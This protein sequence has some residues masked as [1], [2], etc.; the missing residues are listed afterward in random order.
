MKEGLF[1]AAAIFLL[2][3]FVLGFVRIIKGP[4]QAD[5]LLGAQLLGTVGVAVILLLS[6]ALSWEI[7]VDVAL[8]LAFLAAVS[9]I[10]FVAVTQEKPNE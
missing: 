8:L 9:S 6:M 3:T 1:L 10:A 5:S 2:F 7:L 4:S